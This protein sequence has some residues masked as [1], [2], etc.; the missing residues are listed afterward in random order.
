MMMMMMIGLPVCNVAECALQSANVYII[1]LLQIVL[2]WMLNLITL[3][4]I[5]LD[6]FL[7]IGSK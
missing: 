5:E 4:Q 1:L 2:N 6:R 3:L 7:A